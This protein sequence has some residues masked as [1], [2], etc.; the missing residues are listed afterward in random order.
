MPCGIFDKRIARCATERLQGQDN[1]SMRRGLIFASVA[2]SMLVAACAHAHPA[3]SLTQ[4]LV[5]RWLR[6][7]TPG[8]ISS[9]P[10]AQ[11][12]CSNGRWRPPARRRVSFRPSE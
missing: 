8:A 1:L 9:E 10:T 3:S 6:F 7:E 5:D 2:V 12:F 4:V 11:M